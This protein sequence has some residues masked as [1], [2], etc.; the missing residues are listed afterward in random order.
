MRSVALITFFVLAVGTAAFAVPTTQTI[1]NARVKEA[2]TE[3]VRQNTVG[4][5]GDLKLPA[6]E[7]G[8]EVLRRTGGKGGGRQTWPLLSG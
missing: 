6:G 1:P 2:I 3:F 8:F 5:Q 4:F 7:V